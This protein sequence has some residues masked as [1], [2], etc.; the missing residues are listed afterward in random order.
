M[1]KVRNLTEV[2]KFYIKHNTEKSNSEI[3]ELMAGIGVKSIAKY[4]ESLPEKEKS[5]FKTNV[6]DETEEERI[7]RLANGPKTGKLMSH[8]DGV[9]VMTREASEVSDA[10]RT[11]KENN[12]EQRD[13]RVSIHR[14]KD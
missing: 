4:K 13:R 14:P 10:K 11:F 3:A 2:E 7:S 1:A 6:K 9:T 8:R 12:N 5:E